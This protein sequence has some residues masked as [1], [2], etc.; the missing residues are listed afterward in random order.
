MNEVKRMQQA[1][2]ADEGW[3]YDTDNRNALYPDNQLPWWPVDAPG[4]NFYEE[5]WQSDD[6]GVVSTSL[7]RGITSSG[8]GLYLE[9]ETLIGTFSKEV[10]ATTPPELASTYTILS[11]LLK[12]HSRYGR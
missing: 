1:N 10:I 12:W 3:E 9:T 4:A 8:M 2:A 11:G 5:A 6:A 7:V